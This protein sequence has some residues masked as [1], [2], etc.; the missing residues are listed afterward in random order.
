MDAYGSLF[1]DKTAVETMGAALMAVAADIKRLGGPGTLKKAVAASPDLVSEPYSSSDELWLGLVKLASETQDASKTLVDT[2]ESLPS[3]ISGGEE[4]FAVRKVKLALCGPGGAATAGNTARGVATELAERFRAMSKAMEPILMDIAT[5][6]L[7]HLASQQAIYLSSEVQTLE[8]KV[9]KANESWEK[10]LFGKAEKQ[11]TCEKLSA[12]LRTAR[13]NLR[14]SQ[15]YRDGFRGLDIKANAVIPALTKI[16]GSLTALA[17]QFEAVRTT[18]MSFCTHANASQLA[19]KEWV[20]NALGL[21]DLHA[22]W[23][24]LENQAKSF[25]QTCLVSPVG[26]S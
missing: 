19:N 17:S 13:E 9:K 3:L 10:A 4:A 8:T 22:S 2:L 21:P 14:S 15:T 6:P 7:F 20:F 25:V 1:S 24:D 23:S 16:S 18:M 11:E 12:Q 5:S 26:V